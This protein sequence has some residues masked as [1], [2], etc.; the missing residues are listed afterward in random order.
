MGDRQYGIDNQQVL[1]YAHDIKSVYDKGVEIAVVVG[2]GNIDRP[3]RQRSRRLPS[4]KAIKKGRSG[5]V[6][7]FRG[8]IAQ[9]LSAAP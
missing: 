3:V 5:S 8:E 2:G 1:Q 7:V 4:W 9:R 6:E